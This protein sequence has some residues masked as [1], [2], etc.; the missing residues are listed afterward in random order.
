MRDNELQP[1]LNRTER[2]FIP[3]KI[4]DHG[5]NININTNTIYSI[6]LPISDVR[7]QKSV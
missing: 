3:L 4:L 1:K 6:Y 5:I 7:N 2:E